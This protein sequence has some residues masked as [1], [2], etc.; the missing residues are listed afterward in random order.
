LRPK[1]PVRPCHGREAARGRAS[2]GGG[3]RS[4]GILV[5]P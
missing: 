3:L 4:G 5:P 1:R 2:G